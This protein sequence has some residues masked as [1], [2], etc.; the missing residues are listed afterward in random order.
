MAEEA[1]FTPLN[2]KMTERL[3]FKESEVTFL[4]G[5]QDVRGLGVKGNVIIKGREYVVHG[6]DCDLPGCACDAKIIPIAGL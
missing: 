4:P 5:Y 6:M 2:A 3:R 1:V